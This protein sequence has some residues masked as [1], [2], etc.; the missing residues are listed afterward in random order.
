MIKVSRQSWH[1]KLASSRVE[2]LA[3]SDSNLC[4]YFWQVVGSGLV[5]LV[6]IGMLIA[7]LF[8]VVVVVVI[9][10]ALDILVYTSVIWVPIVAIFCLR[11]TGINMNPKSLNLVQE[12][13]KAK[14]EKICPIIEFE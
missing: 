9:V 8:L 6:G 12:Y 10:G 4:K 5:V 7:A 11:K 2:S 14:K 13:L 3:W 1:Y